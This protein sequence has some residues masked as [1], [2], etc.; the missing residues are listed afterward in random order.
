MCDL[1]IMTKKANR[2]PHTPFKFYTKVVK[3]IDRP[4]EAGFALGQNLR[5]GNTFPYLK[6]YVE[7]R[8]QNFRYGNR[9]GIGI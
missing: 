4:I 1:R 5:Y 2:H 6:G 8:D 7:V 3:L 9:Y